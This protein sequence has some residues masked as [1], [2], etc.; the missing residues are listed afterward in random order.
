MLSH[1]TNTDIKAILLDFGKTLFCKT[2][3]LGPFLKSLGTELS[4]FVG[5]KS[6]CWYEFRYCSHGGGKPYW[7]MWGR[8]VMV[9]TNI[10]AA[11]VNTVLR[12]EGTPNFTDI[13]AA[14]LISGLDEIRPQVLSRIREFFFVRIVEFIQLNLT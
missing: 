10:F 13:A 3:T 1:P 9:S 7:E 5:V 8:E 6:R 2:L 4:D 11:S 12:A 14:T